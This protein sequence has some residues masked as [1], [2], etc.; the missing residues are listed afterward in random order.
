VAKSHIKDSRIL[1]RS[2]LRVFLLDEL[3]YSLQLH[4]GGAFVEFANFCIPVEF[5][6][7]EL[8]NESIAAVNFESLR[9]YTLSDL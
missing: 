4:V 1:E 3:E 7:G 2:K 5:F 6:G 9:C 8:F